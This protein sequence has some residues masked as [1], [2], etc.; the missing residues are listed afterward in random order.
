[1]MSRVKIPSNKRHL[2]IA[3]MLIALGTSGVGFGIW[4]ASSLQAEAILGSHNVSPVLP[5]GKTK[6]QLDGW[7]QLT[8]PKGNDT[9]YVYTDS[10]SNVSVNVSQQALPDNFNDN[11]D[12]E[13]ANLA[14]SYNATNKIRA[15]NID[16]YI[17]ASAKGPQSVIFTK[18]GLL[19]MIKSWSEISNEAWISYI[20]SLE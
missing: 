12:S 14:R 6:E 15:N 4:K 3:F 13:V 16:F 10:I 7:Q 8:P 5:K 2:V 9:F 19:I 11:V 20:N 1:M 17:G 18:N